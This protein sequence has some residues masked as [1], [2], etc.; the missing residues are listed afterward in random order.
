LFTVARQHCFVRDRHI[1]SAGLVIVQDA[2]ELVL[3]CCLL[4]TG[5]DERCAIESF[6]FD[7]LIGELR[8]L[9]THIKGATAAIEERMMIPET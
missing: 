5:V 2:F 6:S 8:K 3:Y 4:E 7:Q 1:A 9:A